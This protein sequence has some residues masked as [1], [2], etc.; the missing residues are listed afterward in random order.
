VKGI[1][2]PDSVR[3]IYE[4]T[5]ENCEKLSEIKLPTEL[6]YIGELAF[7]GCSSLKKIIIPKY[8]K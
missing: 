8:V 6:E 2:I 1:L 7:G 5:F 3:E 4:S